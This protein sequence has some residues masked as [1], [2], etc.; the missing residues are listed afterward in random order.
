MSL[1]WERRLRG[2]GFG[3]VLFTNFF[4]RAQRRPPIFVRILVVVA[5]QAISRLPP[6][7]DQCLTWTHARDFRQTIGVILR[8][9]RCLLFLGLN[10]GHARSS[11]FRDRSP[12]ERLRFFKI[13]RSDMP[14]FRSQ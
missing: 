10:V 7:G 8:S 13:R 9:L 11:V 5:Y 6:F 1:V 2:L 14:N 12:L 3:N 4:R